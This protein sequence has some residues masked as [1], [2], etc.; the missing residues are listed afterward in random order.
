MS[1]PPET[2][3]AETRI[4]HLEQRDQRM[5]QLLELLAQRTAA[6]AKSGRDWDAY[7]AV[8]ASFIG[9][10]A[11]A[12]SGYTAYVQRRQLRAQVWPHVELKYST[13][14]L[15]FY[16]SN[17]GTGPA[18]VT[19]MRVT[20]DGAPVNTWD[21]V[22]KIAGFSNEDHLYRSNLSNGVVSPGKD[23]IL[24]QPGDSETS[25]IK[26]AELFPRRKHAI[27]IIVCYCSVL[28]ECWVS[29]AGDTGII[30]DPE[31]DECPITATE[32]FKD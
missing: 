20:V 21:D 2:L 26:F 27:S 8:I 12:V 15:T 3:D 9:M 19:A 13:V 23:F 30:A 6:P 16:A 10:L 28:D 17:T 32:R 18:R 22:H 29:A 7:A 24:I 1:T 31:S 4:A 25:R 5:T 11:L 14:N